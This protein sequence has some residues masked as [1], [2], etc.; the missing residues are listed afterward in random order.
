[1][2]S[3]YHHPLDTTDALTPEIMED[4]AKLLY[5]GVLKLAN[6]KGIHLLTL[7]T[8][9]NGNMNYDYLD[10]KLTHK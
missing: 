2:P 9:T 3:N 6:D 1:M 4:A 7:K 8:V 5:L 10:F